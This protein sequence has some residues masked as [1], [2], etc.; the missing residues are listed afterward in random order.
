MTKELALSEQHKVLLALHHFSAKRDEKVI[1]WLTEFIHQKKSQT[2]RHQSEIREI[3]EKIQT[4]ENEVAE[5]RKHI[6]Q[7]VNETKSNL[8]SILNKVIN[9]IG[10]GPEA[11]L[12]LLFEGGEPKLI[13]HQCANLGN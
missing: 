4:I 13:S 1:A 8:D 6:Q 9:E 7:T 10:V 11:R 3:Q 2:E 12:Q 5:I